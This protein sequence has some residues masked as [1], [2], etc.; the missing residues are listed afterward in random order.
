MQILGGYYD[1]KLVVV[2]N[3]ALHRR[4]EERGSN[5]YLAMIGHDC[6]QRDLY[7]MRNGER[8]PVCASCGEFVPDEIR[9]LWQL[10]CNDQRRGYDT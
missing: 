5:G 1:E 3:W 2:G 4:D 9:G 6:P 7:H 10:M 8:D